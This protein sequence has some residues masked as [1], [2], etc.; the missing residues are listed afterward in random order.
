MPIRLAGWS[1]GRRP[2]LPAHLPAGAGEIA[3]ARARRQYLSSC[4]LA[5][6]AS[7]VTAAK[8]FCCPVLRMLA[9]VVAVVSRRSPCAGRVFHEGGRMDETRAGVK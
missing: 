1:R 6:A 8:A 4:S 3:R 2:A 9:A 7:F 5:V